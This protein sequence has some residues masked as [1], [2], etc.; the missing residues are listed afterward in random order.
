MRKSRKKQEANEVSVNAVR[1]LLL[2]MNSS[3]ASTA[4]R[5][6][7]AEP[8]SADASISCVMHLC[9]ASPTLPTF[10]TCTLH[11]CPA[12]IVK[13]KNNWTP[14]FSDESGS[15]FNVLEN[16]TKLIVSKNALKCYTSVTFGV[17]FA[18][19]TN[20]L[21]VRVHR[22]FSSDHFFP[23]KEFG[24]KCNIFSTSAIRGFL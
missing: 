20:P 5:G 24:G 4:R 14:P 13:L 7:V 19:A 2:F 1:K 10:L 16:Y 17:Q 6:Q 23:K 8:F 11:D 21:T 22:R 18:S 3:M 9:R 15:L 12:F